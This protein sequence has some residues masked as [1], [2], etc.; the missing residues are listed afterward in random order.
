M[1]SHRLRVAA[2]LALTAAM[3]TGCGA[4]V[5]GSTHPGEIDVRTLDVGTYSADPLEMR[6]EYYPDMSKGFELAEQRLADH[7]VNAADVDPEFKYSTGVHAFKDSDGATTVLAKVTAPILDTAKLMFGVAVGHSVKQPDAFGKTPDDSPFT[8][9]TVMQFPD[10]ATASKAAVDL[11]NADFG[12]AADVNQHVSLS[13]YPDAHSHWRPGVASI[14]STLAHGNYVVDTYL[15]VRDPDLSKLTALAEKV[16]DA[17]VP[18]LDSLPP[19]DRE[20]VLRLPFDADGMLRRTLATQVYFAPDFTNQAVAEPRGFLNRVSDQDFWRGAVTD[21]GMDRFATSGASY[22]GISMLFRTRDA[23]AAERLSAA[24]LERGYSGV[25]D[26]P[27]GVPNAKCG[28]TSDKNRSIG[29]KRFRCMVSYRRYTAAVE[30]NQLADAHQRA[31]AQYALLA[32]S[33]W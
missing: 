7:V 21:S 18:L 23:Q 22:D 33:T 30:S 2:L 27:P 24:V 6:Y 25:A 5:Q 26:A 15:G 10:A 17:Q 1:L 3:A 4:T 9:V 32:N 13:K 12:V 14:G 11:E 28:Q 29:A 20:G 31:A 19:L 16:Y 8:T